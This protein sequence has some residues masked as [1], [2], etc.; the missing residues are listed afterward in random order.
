[1]MDIFSIFSQFSYFGIFL[2]LVLVNTAPI[3][4]PPTWLILAS[5]H[6][7]DDTLSPALL[8][9]VGATGATIGRVAL[10]YTSGFFRKFMSEE[11][12]S[13]LDG[14]ANYLKSKKIG[15]FLA[16]FLFAST[17]LPSNMLF[18]G[19]GLMRAKSVQ[20][21]TGFWL[22]RVTSYY[23]MISIS[24]VVL[25]PFAKL[26]EDRMLG[27]ILVDVLSI[28][29]LVFFACI[30]WNMLITQRKIQFVKPKLWRL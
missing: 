27:I 2:L 6:A 10:M 28:L 13:S 30:N 17:P 29:I 3:L 15:Y 5:F 16:S 20:I 26:F 21:Y 7:L 24:H 8:A 25:T 18:I 12:K 4:M 1:M 22:G 19:Y 11:R 14:I 9:I 23:V